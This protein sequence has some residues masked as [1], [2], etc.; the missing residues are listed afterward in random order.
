MLATKKFNHKSAQIFV[1]SRSKVRK[2]CGRTFSEAKLPQSL[3]KSLFLLGSASNLAVKCS[4]VIQV[5]QISQTHPNSSLNPWSKWQFP[6][7]DNR[8]LWWQVVFHAEG[9]T[10]GHVRVIFF[11]E[12]GPQL[13]VEK[14][15]IRSAAF[16]IFRINAFEN[17]ACLWGRPLCQVWLKQWVCSCLAIL[18]KLN[19]KTTSP[20]N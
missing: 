20:P 6:H 4:F 9:I 18:F 10:R 11:T 17:S 16:I 19:Y 1:R 15:D 13:K 12:M 8:I 7:F 3:I 14:S 2:K 5:E